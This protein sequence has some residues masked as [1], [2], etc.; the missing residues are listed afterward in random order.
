MS[1]I[2]ANNDLAAFIVALH[3]AFHNHS[4]GAKKVPMGL[5]L[6]W[7]YAASGSEQRDR[8]PQFPLGA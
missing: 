7:G 8:W 4:Y 3:G 2:R 6:R 1:W 5:N